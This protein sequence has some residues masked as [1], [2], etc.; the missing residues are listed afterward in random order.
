MAQGTIG[1]GLMAKPPRPGIAKT[2]L[3]TAVG[4][5]AAADLAAAFLA[6]TARSIACAA[7]PADLA[8]TLFHRPA[9]AGD[10]LA[11]L[12]GHGWPLIFCDEGEL[13][14]TMWA[15]L[16]RLL[17]RHPAGSLVMGADLPLVPPEV[18]V[19][20]AE[21]L[22]Q[23]DRRTVVVMPSADGGY[24]L[25]GVRSV[26]AA[27]LFA[28]MAW[29]TPRVLA[30]TLRRAEAEG[31]TVHLL[32]EQRDV[33]EPADLAWLRQALAAKPEAAP[34]TRIALARL[35]GGARG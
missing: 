18:V 32:P 28:P 12:V 15:V 16:A 6:D 22:R 27:P 19:E 20:A 17:A 30:E 34:A 7:G 33:D 8:C 13:G 24:G 21:V 26:L 11:A 10:E 5:K 9:D 23:G 35:D 2:R 29:S 3:A 14:A 31:L 25:I 4:E 1:F